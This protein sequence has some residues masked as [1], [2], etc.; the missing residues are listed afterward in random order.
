MR[1]L[2]WLSWLKGIFGP[3]GFLA[4][5]GLALV[6]V[7]LPLLLLRLVAGRRRFSIRALMSLPIAAAIPLMCFLV[8]EP[9]L[10]V[11]TVPFLASERRLFTAGTLAGVPIVFC[12][13]WLARSL[14]RL[15]FKRAL[16]FAAMSLVSSLAIAGLWLWF[17]KKS[18]ATIEQYDLTGWILVSLLGAYVASFFTCLAWGVL[19]I[20]RSVRRASRRGP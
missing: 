10:P 9:V 17:D 1:P 8:L 19:K 7:I 18:M 4:A 13:V 5:A 11:D 2:P 16:G 12:V 20:H 14:A 6:N 15:R 3:W